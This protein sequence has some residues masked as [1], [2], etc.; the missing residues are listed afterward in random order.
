MKFPDQYEGWDSDTKARW[1]AVRQIEELEGHSTKLQTI[2]L[3]VLITFVLD[4]CAAVLL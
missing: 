3:V 2:A 1:L 4:A